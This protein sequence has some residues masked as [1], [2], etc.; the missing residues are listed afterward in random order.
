MVF[1]RA[2]L[3]PTLLHGTTL[4]RDLR[5]ERCS[6]T[7]GRGPD[8]RHPP[9]H[10]AAARLCRPGARAGRVRSPADAGRGVR[11]RRGGTAAGQR[12]RGPGDDVRRLRGPGRAHP[13]RAEV[14]G[15]GA[16]GRIR[17]RDGPGRDERR[18]RPHRGRGRAE[19]RPRRRPRLPVPTA[20]RPG[21]GRR[22]AG[23]SRPTRSS[24]PVPAWTSTR[25]RASTLRSLPGWSGWTRRGSPAPPARPPLRVAA[26]QVAAQQERTRRGRTVQVRPG[27]DGLSEWWALLPTETSAA[28]AAAVEEL[29]TT[30]CADDPALKPRPA[31]TPSP[32]WCSRTSPSPPRSPSASPC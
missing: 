29:A 3:A 4:P 24:T 17:R 2:L 12:C 15:A 31:P 19:G 18:H 32:T 27:E 30:H 6:V 22:P 5:I 8:H 9:R 11:A 23:G 14:A 16:P 13:P 20:A 1:D 7:M 21:A 25:A 10:A 26:D 28:M